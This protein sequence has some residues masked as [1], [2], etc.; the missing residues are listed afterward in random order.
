MH[1]HTDHRIYIYGRIIVWIY[2]YGT[3]KEEKEKHP[4]ENL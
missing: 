1:H 4:A 3:Q 2:A